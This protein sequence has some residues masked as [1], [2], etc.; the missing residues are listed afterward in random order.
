[1]LILCAIF[2]KSITFSASGKWKY[3]MRSIL[4][5]CPFS[6]SFTSSINEAPSVVGGAYKRSLG[7]G[8]HALVGINT[9][10]CSNQIIPWLM[11]AWPMTDAW[12]S[13][14]LPKHICRAVRDSDTFVGRSA[15]PSWLN[16][17]ATNIESVQTMREIKGGVR[18]GNTLRRSAPPSLT[19]LMG[20]V[21]APVSEAILP[22]CDAPGPVTNFY[23]VEPCW[24]GFLLLATERALTDTKIISISWYYFK[25]FR[26]FFK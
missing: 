4:S 5:F 16:V 6:F 22:W 1:M 20:F 25:A 3:W 7:W 9:W 24:T 19:M 10:W 11:R 18:E 2:F 8:H 14:V 12:P 15:K 26:I 21:D 17:L 13:S 23:S